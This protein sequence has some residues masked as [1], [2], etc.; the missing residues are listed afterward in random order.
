MAD[1]LWGASHTP[2]EVAQLVAECHHSFQHIA[3]LNRAWRAAVR[4]LAGLLYERFLCTTFSVDVLSDSS[5]RNI[6]CARNAKMRLDRLLAD[7]IQSPTPQVTF[8]YKAQLYLHRF[9][10][11]HLSITVRD[12]LLHCGKHSDIGKMYDFRQLLLEQ[13]EFATDCRLVK[14]CMFQA[15]GFVT[16]RDLGCGEV[17]YT[18][19]EVFRT[20]Q[21]M[22]EARQ[23]QSEL[24]YCDVF[25]CGSCL[26]QQNQKEGED[27]AS[28]KKAVERA[29]RYCKKCGVYEY[30][31]DLTEECCWVQ[32]GQR[33][34]FHMVGE[35]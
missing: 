18:V 33:C 27:Q 9:C 7:K 5:G 32:T 23:D 25:H 17:G 13:D 10:G 6:F 21:C 16:T 12:V 4:I 24:S 28:Q 15:N 30:W 35:D 26:T 3:C 20:V 29:I 2:V 8:W 34:V 22:I 11:L 14:T 1:I 19:R 31:Q